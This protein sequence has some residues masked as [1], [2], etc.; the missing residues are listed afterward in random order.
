MNSIDLST[1]SIYPVS[2]LISLETVSSASEMGENTTPI[3]IDSVTAWA[4]ASNHKQIESMIIAQYFDQDILGDL[5]NGW[6]K[7]VESGQVWALLIGIVL[8]YL[9]RGIT[10][11]G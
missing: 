7:F 10:T 6:S 9:I 1:V 5:G 11:Y 3:S 4:P 8:G 2:S